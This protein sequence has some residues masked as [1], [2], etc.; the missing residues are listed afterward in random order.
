MILLEEFDFPHY[1]WLNWQLFPFFAEMMT[2]S[3]CQL[4]I[5]PSSSE[6]ALRKRILRYCFCHCLLLTPL[7]DYQNNLLT[8]QS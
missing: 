6:A 3:F 1:Q 8:K 7:K 5:E 4:T 2:S